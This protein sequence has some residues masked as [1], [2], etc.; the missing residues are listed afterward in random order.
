MNSVKQRI[1]NGQIINQKE[2]V[3]VERKISTQQ[4]S[5]VGCDTCVPVL[6]VIHQPGDNAGWQYKLC[7]LPI[8]TFTTIMHYSTLRLSELNSLVYRTFNTSSTVS[9]KYFMTITR[10]NSLRCWRHLTKQSNLIKTIVL[11]SK[12]TTAL[13]TLFCIHC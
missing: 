6:A 10:E 1:I 2:Q 7:L 4:Q 9:G 3:R 12:K 8:F 11:P 13:L 5:S